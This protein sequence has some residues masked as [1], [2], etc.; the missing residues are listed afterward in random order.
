MDKNTFGNSTCAEQLTSILSDINDKIT[1]RKVTSILN[2]YFRG[3]NEI[4]EKNVVA[5]QELLRMWRDK[6]ITRT[7]NTT[8]PDIVKSRV[9]NIIVGKYRNIRKI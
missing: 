2:T 3:I 4:G 1:T 5:K 9:L 6:F 8:I 7:K